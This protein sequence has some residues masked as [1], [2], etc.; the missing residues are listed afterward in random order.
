[1]PQINAN[2]DEFTLD[3]QRLAAKMFDDYGEPVGIDGSVNPTPSGSRKRP[4]T[5]PTAA[6]SRA[7]RR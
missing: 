3:R 6:R 4:G 7:P 2:P 5:P 1:M